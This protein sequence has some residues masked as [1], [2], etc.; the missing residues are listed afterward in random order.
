MNKFMLVMAMRLLAG[1]SRDL[2]EPPPDRAAQKGRSVPSASVCSDARD[3]MTN[4]HGHGP[5]S[6]RSGD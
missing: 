5:P 4:G 6:T 2:A 1:E 3:E